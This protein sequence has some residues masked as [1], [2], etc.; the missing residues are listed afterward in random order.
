MEDSKNREHSDIRIEIPLRLVM[1]FSADWARP[2]LGIQPILFVP[3]LRRNLL[4][5]AFF[6]GSAQLG[7]V[8]AWRRDAG[9]ERGACFMIPCREVLGAAA[10]RCVNLQ[11]ISWGYRSSVPRILA[12]M[13]SDGQI[14]CVFGPTAGQKKLKK[15]LDRVASNR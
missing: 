7:F 3:N 5:C 14:R 9:Q 11:T 6:A 15:P 13:G 10:L 1:C 2:K 12:I 8:V 4:N